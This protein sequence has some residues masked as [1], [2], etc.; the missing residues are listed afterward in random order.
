MG[1]TLPSPVSTSAQCSVQSN[2]TKSLGKTS[3]F[4]VSHASFS[5]KHIPRTEYACN[6]QNVLHRVPL[7]A[8]GISRRSGSLAA[9]C[10]ALLITASFMPKSAQ[11]RLQWVGR[12]KTTALGSPTCRVLKNRWMLPSSVSAAGL[13]RLPSSLHRRL[14]LRSSDIHAAGGRVTPVAEWKAIPLE[15]RAPRD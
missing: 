7:Q 10:P 8:T 13:L 2:A 15:C 9:R 6:K 5:S 3:Q 4:T 12:M 14:P 1:N 11:K